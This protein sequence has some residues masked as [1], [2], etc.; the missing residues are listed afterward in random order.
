VND[1]GFR[2]FVTVR[3]GELLRTAY[4]LTGGRQSAEDLLQNALVRVMRR[5]SRIDDPMAYLHRTMVNQ[6]ISGWRRLGWS[7]ERL[8]AI[9]PEQAVDPGTADTLADRDRLLSALATL[10]AQMRA[11]LVLRYWEDLSEAQTADVLGC[12]KGSVKSQASRGLSR[13]RS[14]LQSE[15]MTE[16]GCP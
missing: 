11:V 13:L 9:V 6:L 7:R 2:E 12:S 16:K 3:Y 15:V 8:T 10:P 4:L 5:W 14:V 1:E